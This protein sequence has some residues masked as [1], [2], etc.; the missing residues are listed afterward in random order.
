MCVD[1]TVSFYHRVLIEVLRYR[2]AHENR[3]TEN[4]F[5]SEAIQIAKLKETK[6]SW[7]CSD[8]LINKKNQKD[9]SLNDDEGNRFFGRKAYR[10]MQRTSNTMQPPLEVELKQ[11]Q[12]QIYLYMT[13]KS[14]SENR[15]V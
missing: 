2:Q 1:W 7:S 14:S 3:E 10:H 15:Y 12:P 11:I 4:E 9:S 5:C 6:T 8:W 13:L